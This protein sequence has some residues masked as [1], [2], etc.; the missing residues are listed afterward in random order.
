MLPWVAEERPAA[1]ELLWCPSQSNE[2]KESVQTLES[3]LEGIMHRPCGDTP[4]GVVLGGSG[5]I[6]AKVPGNSTRLQSPSFLRR[7]FQ[8]SYSRKSFI[9]V[10]SHSS[11]TNTNLFSSFLR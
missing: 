1:H 6:A 4:E 2:K 3:S 7:A 11:F 8:C 10:S 9:P 5:P